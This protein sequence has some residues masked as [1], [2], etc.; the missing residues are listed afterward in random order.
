MAF[1]PSIALPSPNRRRRRMPTPQVGMLMPS[2]GSGGSSGTRGGGGGSYNPPPPTHIQPHINAGPGPPSSISVRTPSGS[3]VSTAI[4]ASVP[5]GNARVPQRL[6]ALVS[7]KPPNS[8]T[9]GLAP[10]LQLIPNAFH[11]YVPD[12]L[13]AAQRY[14][15]QPSV[16][17]GLLGIESK[18]GTDPATFSGSIAGAQG[19][20]QFMPGT[21]SS[22]RGPGVRHGVNVADNP[23]AIRTQIFGAANLLT[24]LGV[25]KDTVRAL[26]A[27]NAGP[28]APTSAAGTYPQDVLN[29]AKQFAVADKI[30]Q[31]GGSS[32]PYV[33]PFAKSKS[34]T[35]SRTD[36][37]VDYTGSGLIN[38]IGK[39]R[40]LGPGQA[41]GPSAG[42]GGTG[43][44][45][46][47]ELL[48]G[49]K[50]GKDVF[51]YEGIAPAGPKLSPGDII[52]KGQPIASFVPGGSIE[53]GWSDASG[54]PI[55]QPTYSEGDV[56]QPGLHFQKFLSKS[57]AASPPGQAAIS[58]SGT[59]MGGVPL[60]LS[61]GSPAY[62]VAAS[63]GANPIAAQTAVQSARQQN[64]PAAPALV[65]LT[66]PSAPTGVPFPQ[67]L[68]DLFGGNL[69]SLGG[70]AASGPASGM[71]TTDLA[72]LLAQ[73]QI[74]P[75]NPLQALTTP[76]RRR[77]RR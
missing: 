64:Q 53:T 51:L 61:P 12:V 35:Q 1:G 36:E 15:V 56:T 75:Q 65:S 13:A 8:S 2:G 23:K 74:A 55:A 60:G 77:K 24:S 14:N 33:S 47:Y 11:P 16:L 6:A 49:P 42:G 72:T 44:G 10:L 73:L 69:P 41:W 34:F 50:K 32:G 30:A 46:N 39:A 26:A 43:Y 17:F 22:I 18:F 3:R 40:Y 57:G 52:R 29:M 37:G 25:Q 68:A 7:L 28:A 48:K 70:G 59:G 54:A 27:Y 5:A 58:G 4:P 63:T 66:P 9:T 71:S 19:V 45:V 38:A 21:A 76:T 62:S 31:S 20:S 67:A